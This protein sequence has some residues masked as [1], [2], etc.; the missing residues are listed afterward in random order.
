MTATLST[1]PIAS[2]SATLTLPVTKGRTDRIPAGTEVSIRWDP[3]LLDSGTPSN[4]PAAPSPEPSTG[5]VSNWAITTPTPLPD[6]PEV[7]LVVPEAAGSVVRVPP[8]V[9]MPW[10]RGT[11]EMTPSAPSVLKNRFRA[12]PPWP[13][14]PP[15]GAC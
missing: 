5:P 4:E 1:L 13:P 12:L 7:D 8:M 10:P 15:A 14:R 6:A 2:A 3:I 11:V 9:Y